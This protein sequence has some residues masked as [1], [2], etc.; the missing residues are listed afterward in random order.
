MVSGILCAYTFMNTAD[1]SSK[2]AVPP[3]PEG[4]ETIVLGAGC[5][6]CTESVFQQLPGVLSVIS[7]YMGGANPHPTYEQICGGN[8]GHAEVSRIVFDPK[9]LSLEALLEV[10]WKMHDPTTLNRQ[11]NDV[12][13]QYRSAIFYADERQRQIAQA[14]AEAAAKK[15]A[16]PI[17]TE[18]APAS[19]FYP[20][21]QYHQDY[22]RQNKSRNPYC[23]YVITPKLRK[24][25]LES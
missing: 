21:E 11:G 23:A 19:E 25:G 17:M 4:A 5:F 20:A 1:L 13:T 6:W 10:F 3:A 18:I 7:G 22:Y 2:A 9:Q 14:S 16:A 15:F 24:L 12:G 8:T